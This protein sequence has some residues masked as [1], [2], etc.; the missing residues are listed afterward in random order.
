MSWMKEAGLPVSH[1][2]ASRHR[3]RKEHALERERERERERHQPREISGRV[4]FGCFPNWA[5]G[6]RRD[7]RNIIRLR[8]SL[9]QP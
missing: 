6:S 8:C 1:R 3:R 7:I 9:P 4:A 2:Q 5:S